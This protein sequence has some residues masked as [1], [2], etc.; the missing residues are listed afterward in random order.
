MSKLSTW[1]HGIVN[2][3][4][5]AFT[6]GKPKQEP[7]NP[8]T[9]STPAPLEPDEP[10]ACT[11]DLSKPLVEPDKGEE[12]PVPWGMDIRFLAWSTDAHDWVFIGCNDG[13]IVRNGKQLTG[14][15]FNKNGKQYHYIG[16]RAPSSS[17]SLVQERT[18]T[19]K[20]TYRLYYEC[21]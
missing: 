21:R 1:W 10:Q 17:S 2:A 8:Q 19:Y 15:C 7:T 3:I 4:K 13:S 18:G 9:D 11:C 16:Y 20:E 12:C 14:R 6:W 5:F